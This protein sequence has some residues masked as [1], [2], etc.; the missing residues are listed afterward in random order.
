MTAEP[1]PITVRSRRA[2]RRQMVG[3]VMEGLASLAA[4]AA[5][6]VLALVVYAV[7]RRG[8]PALSKDFFTQVPST[9][10]Y[11]NPTGGVVNSIIGSLI[12]TGIATMISVPFGVLIAIYDVEFAPP[13]AR[14]V[15][16][17]ALNVLAGVPT[18]VIGVFIFGLLV[19]GNGYSA[20]AAS[21]ALSIVMVPL[22]ARS[23]EEVLALVP[24]HLRE[25]GMAL[26][27]TRARTVLTVILPTTFGGI[28]TGTVLAVAR[29]AGETAPLLFTSAIFA[30]AISTDPSKAMG[31]LPM[32]IYT[33]SE[34]PSQFA[35]QQAWGAALVLV[36]VVLV[37]SILGRVLSARN[38]RKLGR[39]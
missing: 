22:V 24:A 32:V 7:V 2:R 39:V 23:T 19:V 25:G 27:A 35:Q 30:N 12:I 13:R 11:G 26:G 21:I 3:W 34:Q 37:A 38:R 5:L 31:S 29:A 9:D 8:F 15:I 18:V 28:V 33:D 16:Q 10:A 36:A 1:L 20:Y 6:V 17:L 4:L 14:H